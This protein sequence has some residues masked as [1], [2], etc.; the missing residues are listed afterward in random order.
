VPA[1]GGRARHAGSASAAAECLWSRRSAGAVEGVSGI[2]LPGRRTPGPCQRNFAGKQIN[3]S[4][5]PSQAGC[6]ASGAGLGHGG[7][8]SPGPQC[9][10]TLCQPPAHPTAPRAPRDTVGAAPARLRRGSVGTR[11]AQHG[12]RQGGWTPHSTEGPGTVPAPAG[13]GLPEQQ[14]KI[15]L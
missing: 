3:T 4:V 8:V 11:A 14:P 7:V 5:E 15:C 13:E 2:F 12:P 1:V 6:P 10:A 9:P